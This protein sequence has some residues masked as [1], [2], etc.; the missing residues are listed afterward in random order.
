MQ[1]IPV[2]ARYIRQERMVWNKVWNK[3]ESRDLL[4][5]KKSAKNV[6]KLPAELQ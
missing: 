4:R 3:A 2:P 5:V 1:S 6:V